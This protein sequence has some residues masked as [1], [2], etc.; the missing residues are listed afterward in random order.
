MI[1]NPLEEYEKKFK[2]LHLYNTEKFFEELSVKSGVNIEENK[3]TVQKYNELTVK[4]GELKK[5]YNL[6][7]FLRVLACI[8]VVLIYYVVKK[9]TPQIQTLRSEIQDAE[10]KALQ[11]LKQAEEQMIPLNSLFTDKDSLRIIE[12]TMPLVEFGSCFTAQQEE[13]MKTNYD[14]D[15]HSDAEQTTLDVLAGRYN[16]NPFIFEKKLVHT[17][18]TE[19]YHGYKEISWVETY[20]DS[21]GKMQSRTEHQTLH[22]TVVKP[23]PF[24]HTQVVL[25]YG[26]QGAPELTFSRDATHLDKKSEGSIERYV[27]KGEKRLK[28]KEDKAL[29][30]NEEF[31]SMSNAEFEVLFDALDRNDEVQFRTLFTPLA[32]TNMVDLILA[33]N[34]YGDDFNFIKVRRMNQIASKHSQGRDIKLL[35]GS[36]TSYSYEQ[37]KEN[38]INKNQEYFKAVYFDFAPLL[39]IPVYQERPVHSLKPIPDLAKRYSYKECEVLANAMEESLVVHPDT[40]TEAILKTEFL[41]S[42]NDVDETCI[43]AYSYDI[44]QRVDIVPMR[45]GDGYMHDVPVYWDE[46]LP[47]EYETTFSVTENGTYNGEVK[48]VRNGLCIY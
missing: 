41:R 23:K 10:E 9:M 36:Y 37:I 39:A 40:K 15:V 20:R 42:E 44:E 11:L 45:G 43:T 18:G 47:L 30:N 2:S 21:N 24:Y 3:L 6:K 17:M 46:Y 16:E 34:G 8:S 1:F 19:T 26:A 7:R 29:K 32:Q 5:K 35:P 25:N 13:D 48:A 14:Y 22:A 33:K 38:F 27:K 4:K 31:T 28:R 12:K